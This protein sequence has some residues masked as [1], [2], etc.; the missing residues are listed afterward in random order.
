MP[1]RERLRRH[2]DRQAPALLQR[3]VILRPVRDL[4][5]R[6]WD[7]VAARLIGLVGHSS[8]EEPGSS[9]IRSAAQSPKPEASELCT[10][11]LARRSNCAAWR[12]YGRGRWSVLPCEP[13]EGSGGL[14]A[15]KAGHSSPNHRGSARVMAGTKAISSRVTNS[16]VRYLAIGRATRS[17][18]TPPTAQAV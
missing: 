13:P 3:P 11:A 14:L 17:I 12:G 8:S 4:V 15:A 18:G 10:N 1:G 6:P 9:P 5:A 7:L 16:T 2:P